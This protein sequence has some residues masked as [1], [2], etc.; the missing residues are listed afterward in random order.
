MLVRRH[1]LLA[2]VEETVRFWRDWVAPVDYDGR[3]RDAV[4]RS[5][6][7][8]GVCLHRETGALLAAATMSLPESVGGD[9][10]WDY[11][12]CWLRDTALALNAIVQLRRRQ[13]DHTTLSWVPRAT[14]R[15]HPRLAPFDT[16]DG[17]TLSTQAEVPLRGWRDTRPVLTGNHAGAQLQLGSWGDLMETVYHYVDVGNALDRETARRVAELTEQATHAMLVGQGRQG[18]RRRGHAGRRPAQLRRGPGAQRPRRAARRHAVPDRLDRPARRQAQRADDG[19]LRHLVH[20]RHELPLQRVAAPEGQARGV[21]VD[22]DARMLGVRY[23]MEVD[24]GGDSPD[25]L[26]ALIPLLQR[27]EDRS[28]RQEIEHNIE[29]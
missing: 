28:W 27:K 11:G 16:L 21:Q 29:R 4:R 24:L 18:G 10:T 15:T 2:R 26:Q 20:G 23:P 22:I 3:Y 14:R 9:A 19:R 1:D 17:E 13:L 7:A 5:V 8:L 12:Y 25:T 6:L